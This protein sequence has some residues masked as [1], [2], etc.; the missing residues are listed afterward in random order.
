MKVLKGMTF[1]DK[2]GNILTVTVVQTFLDIEYA[3]LNDKLEVPTIILEKG[4]SFKQVVD[5]WEGAL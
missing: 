3:V 4:E 5:I 2:Q 1:K